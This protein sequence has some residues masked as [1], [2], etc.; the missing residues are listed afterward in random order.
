MHSS[1]RRLQECLKVD[2]D[3]ANVWIPQCVDDLI[4]GNFISSNTHQSSNSNKN[5]LTGTY[6]T[7]GISMTTGSS[8]SAYSESYSNE[9]NNNN[10]NSNKTFRLP[11][12]FV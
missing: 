11:N 3:G 8:S 2:L 9:N 1:F 10:S 6:T 12:Y 4:G 7:S 5:S